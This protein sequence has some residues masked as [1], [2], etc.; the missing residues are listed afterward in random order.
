M[1]VLTAHL[2]LVPLAANTRIEKHSLVT[3][4]VLMTPHVS[5]VVT[6]AAGEMETM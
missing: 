1:A 3:I 4:E 5:H 6:T 2:W